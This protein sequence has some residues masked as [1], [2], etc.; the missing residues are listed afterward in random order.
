[1][2]MP[3]RQKGISG[4]RCGDKRKRYRFNYVF[5]RSPAGQIIL[6]LLTDE[7]VFDG[8]KA[9]C[10]DHMLDTGTYFCS[11]F[12]IDTQHDDPH[13]AAHAARR[14]FLRWRPSS[15]RYINPASVTN[16]LIFSRFSWRY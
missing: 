1:M 14:S 9:F 12:R 6:R 5:T 16:D 13:E 8:S 3:E 11:Y 7:S 2:G 10:T 15:V 4:Y